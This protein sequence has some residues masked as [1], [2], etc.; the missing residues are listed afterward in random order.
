MARAQRAGFIP[1]NR[2]LDALMRP[3]YGRGLDALHPGELTI[4]RLVFAQA[5]LMAGAALAADSETF[6]GAERLWR[7][8]QDKIGVQ[9]RALARRFLE[10]LSQDTY[11]SESERRL[12][13]TLGRSIS[14]GAE[15]RVSRRECR[16]TEQ[17]L[18]PFAKSPIQLS[19]STV[20]RLRAQRDSFAPSPREL[21]LLFQ[22]EFGQGRSAFRAE[23]LQI[24]RLVFGQ[25]VLMV[26]ALLAADTETYLG[27]EQLW[28][29]IQ[30]RIGS[31]ERALARRFLGQLSK[32]SHYTASERQLI[33][34][35]ADTL[36]G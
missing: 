31:H 26:G 4:A 14:D 6:F 22:A 2:E 29:D 17:P 18:P 15:W 5:A 36:S 12:I 7:N 24:A 8:M 3:I 19:E 23:E 16:T 21:M 28:S 1:S 13:R 11:Y 25:V 34:F 27:A 9:E 32:D 35:L 33:D 30:D 10:I 20:A